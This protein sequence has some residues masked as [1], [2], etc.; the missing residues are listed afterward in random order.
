MINFEYESNLAETN[1]KVKKSIFK[2]NNENNIDDKIKLENKFKYNNKKIN[3]K[4]DN[5][6]LKLQYN[7]IITKYNKAN[8]QLKG[9]L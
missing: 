6:N 2:L 9:I 1:K 5:N 7:K 8:N 3:D 4:D